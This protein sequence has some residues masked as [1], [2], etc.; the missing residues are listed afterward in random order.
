M[1]NHC[2]FRR[3]KAKSK[4]NEISFEDENIRNGLLKYQQQDFNN[5][6]H[7]FNSAIKDNPTNAEIYYFRGNTKAALKDFN[8][9]I[10]DFSQAIDLKPEVSDFYYKKGMVKLALDDYEGAIEEY[11]KVIEIYPNNPVAY[12]KRAD[13]RLS[14]FQ[15]NYAKM[16]LHRAAEL[17]SKDAKKFLKKLGG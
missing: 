7:Y 15:I 11:T 1:L 10:D 14:M 16:D 3:S 6:I 12:M 2:W 13:L 5:A 4:K 9:A 8:G 17:G